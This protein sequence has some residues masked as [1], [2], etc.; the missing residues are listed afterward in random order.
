[1]RLQTQV[2]VNQGGDSSRDVFV[3]R[4]Q[5]GLTTFECRE[6]T[7][8]GNCGVCSLFEC[9]S[10]F[11][12]VDESLDLQ[13]AGR[14]KFVKRESLLMLNVGVLLKKMNSMEVV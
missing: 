12:D 1:M 7:H 9:V 13:L 14:Y 11:C 4:L 6:Q 8:Y 10:E 5:S 3:I 2:I